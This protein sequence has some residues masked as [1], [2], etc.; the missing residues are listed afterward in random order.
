MVMFF[1][2]N[3]QVSTK[4]TLYLIIS[5]FVRQWSNNWIMY[6]LSGTTNK[7]KASH[8]GNEVQYGLI[9]IF[10]LD[11]PRHFCLIVWHLLQLN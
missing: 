6:F 5:A 1:Q 10:V 4:E 8:S 7:W 3:L 9:S 11:Q 2:E